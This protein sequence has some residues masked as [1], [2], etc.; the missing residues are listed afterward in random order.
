MA[1]LLP[2][3]SSQDFRKA[4]QIGQQHILTERGFDEGWRE[5]KSDVWKWYVIPS[6]DSGLQ[7]F[8]SDQT[9]L[10]PVVY[11]TFKKEES[12]QQQHSVLEQGSCQ[13]AFCVPIPFFWKER[14]LKPQAPKV[15][16]WNW[17]DLT[18]PQDSLNPPFRTPSSSNATPR[19]LRSTLQLQL[20]CQGRHWN[21]KCRG[22]TAPSETRHYS[23]FNDGSWQLALEETVCFPEESVSFSIHVCLGDVL[24]RMAHTKLLNPTNS[25][26]INHQSSEHSRSS[27]SAI[28]HLESSYAIGLLHSTD[29]PVTSRDSSKKKGGNSG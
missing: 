11:L 19:E 12:K 7:V 8:P 14:C 15:H 24:S 6:L 22:V 26:Q 25:V 4:H 21:P 18:A 1:G 20:L 28:G 17:F 27:S 13:L 9:R 16:C 2:L 29:R 3:C 10:L 23:P 5:D